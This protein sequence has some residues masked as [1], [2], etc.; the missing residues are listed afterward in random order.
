MTA[1]VIINVARQING[2]YVFVKAEKAFKEKENAEKYFKSLNKSNK[3]L[4]PLNSGHSI[5]CFCEYSI[6]D[7]EL[8]D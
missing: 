8:E 6:F 4:I 1:F 5:E 3:Q 7:I 2:E